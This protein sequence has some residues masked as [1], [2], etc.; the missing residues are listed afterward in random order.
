MNTVA[1]ENVTVFLKNTKNEPVC[2]SEI[3]LLGSESNEVSEQS[4]EIDPHQGCFVFPAVAAVWH[5]PLDGRTHSSRI[6]PICSPS[7]VLIWV[8][9]V[10]ES[11]L[12]H[13]GGE[14]PVHTGGIRV[15][16][17][18]SGVWG[19]PSG[20]TQGVGV[21]GWVYIRQLCILCLLPRGAP[22]CWTSRLLHT[23]QSCTHTHSVSPRWH[24]WLRLAWSSPPCPCGSI[25]VKSD[26]F[27]VIFILP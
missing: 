13:A 20:E 3:Q 5:P 11:P 2:G 17:E 1:K 12:P 8:C 4:K 26:L 19:G 25:Y 23:H 7:I 21:A 9:L 6:F 15:R 14:T 22:A 16:G 24:L 10:R 27:C 18:M